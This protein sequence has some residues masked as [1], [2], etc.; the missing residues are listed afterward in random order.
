[1]VPVPSHLRGWVVPISCSGED[2]YV[3]ASVRCPCRNEDLEFHYPGTTHFSYDI[4]EP[5]PCTAELR[6]TKGRGRFYF[7]IKAVCIACKTERVLFD[8]DLHGWEI[9]TNGSEYAAE[10]AALPRPRLFVWRC[11][12]CGSAAHRGW[13]GVSLDS[14][15]EFLDRVGDKVGEDRWA[16]AFT[17][18]DMCLKCCGC[19]HESKGWVSYECR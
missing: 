2:P 18:F 12:E 5:I 1:M 14:K 3:K 15:V 6:Q 17:W 13:V 19:G 16:D 4:D 7:G 8:C 9:V 10:K 11:L